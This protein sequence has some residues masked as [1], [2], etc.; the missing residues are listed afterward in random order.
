VTGRP[1][2]LRVLLLLVGAVLAAVMGYVVE[3]PSAG[4]R[5]YTPMSPGQEAPPC[6]V[7]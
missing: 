4:S 6:T 7:K 5:C 1:W 3:H 2:W